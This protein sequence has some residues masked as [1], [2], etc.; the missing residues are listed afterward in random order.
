MTKD[1]WTAC[2][3]HPQGPLEECRRCQ[4]ALDVNR[5]T[6]QA[7]ERRLGRALRADELFAHWH[8]AG[9]VMSK[10]EEEK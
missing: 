6:I 10:T 4:T 1:I 3:L 7:V 5:P 2:D 9:G 8:S